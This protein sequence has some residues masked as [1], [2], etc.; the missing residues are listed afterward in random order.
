MSILLEEKK[1]TKEGKFCFPEKPTHLARLR[2]N[3]HRA[4]ML[5]K[6]GFGFAL[7]RQERH[8]PLLARF[9][10]DLVFSAGSLVR[11]GCAF[12]HTLAKL[13][14]AFKGSDAYADHFRANPATSAAYAA[15]KCTCTHTNS[16]Q[17]EGNG[18]YAMQPQTNQLTARAM[19]VLLD[20]GSATGTPCAV[21][22][23]VLGS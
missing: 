14:C 6:R 17:F 20:R 1:E 18:Q 11:L 22:C 12:Q 2:A 9:A 7:A 5:R 21:M 3:R 8:D 4:R 13:A 16:P 10:S 23:E 19:R 15:T